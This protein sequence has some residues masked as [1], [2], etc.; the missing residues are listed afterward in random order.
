[1]AERNFVRR[2]KGENKVKR[3]RREGGIWL[4]DG[5]LELH[6]SL[7]AMRKSESERKRGSKDKRERRYTAHATTDP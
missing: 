3:E 6:C 7:E 4:E 2:S 5:A 1:M